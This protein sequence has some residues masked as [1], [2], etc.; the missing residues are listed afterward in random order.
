MPLARFQQIGSPLIIK[1]AKTS[2]KAL[3]RC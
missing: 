1:H 2:S 3:A